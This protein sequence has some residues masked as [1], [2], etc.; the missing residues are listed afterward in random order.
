MRTLVP[1]KTD[2]INM[3]ECYV[4]EATEPPLLKEMARNKERRTFIVFGSESV[5][6]E[7]Y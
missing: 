7:D 2:V 4:Q 5:F 1:D 3:T 6:A